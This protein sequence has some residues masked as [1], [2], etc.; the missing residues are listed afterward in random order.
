MMGYTPGDDTVKGKKIVIPY[1]AA[2]L[3]WWLESLFKQ[4]HSYKGM[5]TCIRQGPPKVD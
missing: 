2:G 5:L 4:R 3:D 1:A